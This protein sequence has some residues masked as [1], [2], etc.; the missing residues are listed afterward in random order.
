MLIAL[1]G[2]EIK[3]VKANMMHSR[4][5]IPLGMYRSI[6]N[7]AHALSSHSVGMQPYGLPNGCITTECLFAWGC[8][9][10]TERCK[11]TAYK[12]RLKITKI[13]PHKIRNNQKIN[14]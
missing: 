5:Y 13:I 1:L 8:I 12:I 11:P 4:Y 7:E 9:F 6:E 2:R 3:T 10:S 14:N